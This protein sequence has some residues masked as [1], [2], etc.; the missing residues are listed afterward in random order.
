[1]ECRIGCGACCIIPS[2]STKTKLLPNGKPSH[3]PCIH[4]DDKMRCLIFDHA[5][6]PSVCGSLKP[7][8]EMCGNNRDEAISYL[9]MLDELTK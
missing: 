3:T 7:S 4:L 8:F 1:M 6:R 2:I 9:I 5:E